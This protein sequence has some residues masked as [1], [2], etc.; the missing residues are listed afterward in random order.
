MDFRWDEQEVDDSILNRNQAFLYI[1]VASQGS[2]IPEILGESM[3][4]T[5]SVNV[6]L[7]YQHY[8]KS[9]MGKV[10]EKLGIARLLT[11]VYPAPILHWR[12]SLQKMRPSQ[13][14]GTVS[15]GAQRK[16]AAKA[17]F[18]PMSKSPFS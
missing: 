5:A 15:P 6:V 2:R 1:N 3:S 14:V 10:Q 18:K 11:P 12:V 13:S 8:P 9:S 7:I 17:S 16:E 4:G